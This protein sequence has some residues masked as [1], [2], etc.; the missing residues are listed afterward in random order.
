VPVVL[1]SRGRPSS[2]AASRCFRDGRGGEAGDGRRGHR[3]LGDE[4]VEGDSVLRVRSCDV[5][6]PRGQSNAVQGNAGFAD[7]GPML[8]Q[9]ALVEQSVVSGRQYFA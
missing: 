5:L 4:P 6:G 8:V 2:R 9:F 1:L 7:R 3:V